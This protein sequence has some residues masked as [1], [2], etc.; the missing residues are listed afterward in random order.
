MDCA[1]MRGDPESWLTKRDLVRSHCRAARG[2][3]CLGH[4]REALAGATD[5]RRSSQHTQFKSPEIT[6]FIALW[7]DR[8]RPSSR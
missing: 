5:Y 4:H 3:V 8:K 2:R 6:G 7:N 1:N